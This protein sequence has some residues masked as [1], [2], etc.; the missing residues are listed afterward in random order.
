MP[1]LFSKWSLQMASV[2]TLWI[3]TL[4]CV[5]FSLFWKKTW[6]IQFQLTIC[7]HFPKNAMLVAWIQNSLMTEWCSWVCSSM[8]FWATIKLL[9]ANWFW[10]ILPQKQ[11][12]KKVRIKLFSWMTKSNR[13]LQT[14]RCSNR[15]QSSQNRSQNLRSC[16]LSRSKRW[17]P[18]PSTAANKV[19]TKIWPLIVIDF[20]HSEFNKAC[21]D[22]IKQIKDRFLD[23]NS[24]M[25]EDE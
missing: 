25:V 5:N 4:Q 20:N 2:F 8:P 9:K 1:I 22:I 11:R 16:S 24:V 12:I 18:P 13:R 10:R 19:S 7:L 23:L 6:M 21:K 3:G 17:W 15:D 14:K